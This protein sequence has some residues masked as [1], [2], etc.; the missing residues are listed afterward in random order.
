[1]DRRRYAAFV[2][3]MFDSVEKLMADRI[4]RGLGGGQRVVVELGPLRDKEDN[5]V[6]TDRTAELPHKIQGAGS[7][8][9]LIRFQGSHGTGDQR[10]PG[11]RC[12]AC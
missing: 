12:P 1:M 11:Q 5:R 4:T 10:R 3:E 2:E 7:T 9:E 8:I 6:N